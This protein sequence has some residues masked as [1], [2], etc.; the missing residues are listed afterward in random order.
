MKRCCAC[1][2]RTRPS[3][4]SKATN[5]RTDQIPWQFSFDE[6]WR[7]RRMPAARRTA[8]PA[9]ARRAGPRAGTAP[10][11]PGA[12]PGRGCASPSR[13]WCPRRRSAAITSRSRASRPDR[14]SP[15]A[16][17]ETA[18]RDAAP[19]RAPARAA[20]A[21]RPTARAPAR[22]RD[23]LEP[24][25]RSASRA[26]SLAL[27]PAT[28]ASFERIGHIGQRR[29]AQHAPAAGTP[30]PGGAARRVSARSRR[31]CRRSAA[32]RPCTEP[33]QHALAR[34][35]GPEDDGARPGVES[36]ARCRR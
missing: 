25:L 5:V 10:R 33:H 13:S 32:S 18:P 9:R 1:A 21:R 24:D 27:A 17:R 22:S 30:S 8:R 3:A 12:A 4:T 2:R 26:R 16:R 34:A 29:A 23:A 28:P 31:R 7:P 14:G 35:V 6:S 15:S 20:A 36:A 11:R 19:R